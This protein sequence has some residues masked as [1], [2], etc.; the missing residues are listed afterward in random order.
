MGTGVLKE[1]VLLENPVRKNSRSQ[2][3]AILSPG[4]RAA[5]NES[6]T[7]PDKKPVFA[8]VVTIRLLQ[9]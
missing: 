2:G 8:E 6:F 5:K 3:I 7:Q 1:T 9:A 4:Q